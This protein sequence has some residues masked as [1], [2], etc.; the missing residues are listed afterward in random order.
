[1]MKIK[2]LSTSLSVTMAS[3]R[4]KGQAPTR[5]LDLIDNTV[6]LAPNR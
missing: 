3:S 5:P 2:T 1:M 4:R 6:R